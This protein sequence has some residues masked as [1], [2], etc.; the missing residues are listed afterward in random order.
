MNVRTDAV[1]V[2]GQG[3]AA[4]SP[5]ADEIAQR[6][7]EELI[8]EEEGDAGPPRSRVDLVAGVAYPRVPT[9]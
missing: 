7:T 3:S 1:A 6:R 4:L 2:K 5:E 9:G 8:R